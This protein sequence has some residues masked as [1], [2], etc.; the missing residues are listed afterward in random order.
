MFLIFWNG[1]IFGLDLIWIRIRNKSRFDAIHG[2]RRQSWSF[3]K[4][5]MREKSL[6]QNVLFRGMEASPWPCHSF[7]VFPK[8]IVIILLKIVNTSFFGNRKFGS[9]F[10]PTLQWS[11]DPDPPHGLNTSYV[12]YTLQVSPRRN[13]M[14]SPGARVRS[15]VAARTPAGTKHR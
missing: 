14:T 8:M 12:L 11:L 7:L 1:S 13:A 4:K 9:G 6:E 5:K 10:D 15:R 3:R 2:S